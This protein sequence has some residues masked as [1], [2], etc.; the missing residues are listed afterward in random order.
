VNGETALT[1]EYD[2]INRTE[3]ILDRQHED[4]MMFQYDA[5]GRI[6]Q[7]VPR[8]PVD[9]VRV[10]YDQQGHITRLVHGAFNI[11]TAYDDR[12]R[13]MERRFLARTVY[14]YSYKNN[15]KVWVLSRC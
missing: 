9:G 8:R 11:T 10:A 6:I 5:S 12:G 4:L 14:R 2:R 1:F 15:T 7:V 13:L 3:T